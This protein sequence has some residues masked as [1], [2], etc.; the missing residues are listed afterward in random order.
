M[1]FAGGIGALLVL[2][3]ISRPI[4]RDFEGANRPPGRRTAARHSPQTLGQS[5][6]FDGAPRG[7]ASGS[8]RGDRDTGSDG[9]VATVVG[10]V[11]AQD[12][13]DPI[14]DAWVALLPAGEAS[15]MG[16]AALGWARSLADGSFAVPVARLATAA[17][18]VIRCEGFVKGGIAGFTVGRPNVDVGTV[19]LARAAALAVRVRLADGTPVEG[20]I[21]T[22]WP[23]DSD[24][25][26]AD[27]SDPISAAEQGV[28]VGLAGVQ[29]ASATT[30]E[31]G[32]VVLQPLVAERAHRVGVVLPHAVEPVAVANVTPPGEHEFTLAGVGGLRI[33]ID[34][35][36]PPSRWRAY[37]S[38]TSEDGDVGIEG[39]V[40][41]RWR[42]ERLVVLPPGAYSLD[43]ESEAGRAEH[44][45]ERM[46]VSADRVNVVRW[47][48]SAS[49]RLSDVLLRPDHGSIPHGATA[50]LNAERGEEGVS[51]R[52]VLSKDGEAWIGEAPEEEG[53]VC[54]L[55]WRPEVAAHCWIGSFS[56]PTDGARQSVTVVRTPT[57]TLILQPGDDAVYEVSLVAAHGY[58]PLFARTLSAP[59]RLVDDGTTAF[60]GPQALELF[61]LPPGV[62]RLRWAARGGGGPARTASVDLGPG[63]R[64]VVEAR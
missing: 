7:P 48:L 44:H 6:R 43:L 23:Q 2:W 53:G 39:F 52:T 30:D 31:S 26:D 18:L 45:V 51:F 54:V 57:G 3:Y 37:L 64:R 59:A 20:A 36:A 29:G 9:R 19:H 34:G 55:P 46:D 63:D 56:P 28:Q 11:C 58:L 40:V 47:R 42:S 24:P 32:R 38:R 5:G 16:G 21:V 41:D 50:M 4:A 17:D 49:D 22:A 1:A 60:R 35:A 62:Y 25:R 33:R 12:T 27:V 10:R 61:G 14:P 13:T 15:V 8:A